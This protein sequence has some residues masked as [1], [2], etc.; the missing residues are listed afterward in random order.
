MNNMLMIYRILEIAPA[1][2]DMFSFLRDS[3]EVPHNNPKLKAH[4]VK[5]FK[6]VY[7]TFFF[8]ERIKTF[9][10]DSNRKIYILQYNYCLK[11]LSKIQNRFLKFRWK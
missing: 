9:L 4:A 10:F 2:K 11:L 5:V 7:L 1:A 8:L 6:M 3:D